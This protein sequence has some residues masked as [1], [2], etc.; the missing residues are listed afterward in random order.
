MGAC[1]REFKGGPGSPTVRV[2]PSTGGRAVDHRTLY[3]TVSPVKGPSS[4]PD[5]AHYLDIQALIRGLQQA[6]PDAPVQRVETHISWVL[7]TRDTAYKIK[8]PVKFTFVDFTTVDRR[9]HFCT[10]ELRLNRRLAPEIYL[11]VV[12][13]SRHR[14]SGQWSIDRPPGPDDEIVDWAVKMKA[15]SA[16]TL[17]HLD[18]IAPR[19]IDAI[20]DRIAQFHMRESS[21]PPD[22]VYGSAEQI[23]RMVM[24]N[25]DE[26]SALLPGDPTIAALRDWTQTA[27][28]RLGTW[29]TTRPA[30]GWIKACHGDLHLANITLHHDTPVIFDCIEFSD[31]LRCIDVINEVAFLFMDLMA[32][33]QSPMAW[34]FVN[35][36]CETTGD[37]EGLI[38]LPL[39]SIYRALVRAK[40]H[41][42]Q[43]NP[44]SAQ[45][46]LALAR[47]LSTPTS[48]V[49]MLM[50]GF[51]GSGKTVVAQ[52]RL[53]SIGMVRLRSDVERK[54]LHA[55]I[56]H[57]TASSPPLPDL[58]SAEIT[59]RTFERLKK[60]ARQ[61][62]QAG[63][64]VIVDATFLRES[65]RA[66]FIALA[67]EL[68]VPITILSVQTDIDTCRSRILARQSEG[69]DAS[70][71][72]LAV[73]EHQWRTHDPLT[74]AERQITETYFCAPS[75]SALRR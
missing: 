17:N 24:G 50:H 15:F 61:L 56:G 47:H 54:R 57:T 63:L 64:S 73:L 26:L 46:Y 31:A 9:H 11:D 66:S 67:R 36:W 74:D 29:W 25:L 55:Q 41:L 43:G 23:T 27:L 30:E 7:I 49:L 44:E 14:H 18:P 62:M 72:T 45:R 21:L 68:N 52:Q 3:W 10:E 16:P 13:I 59:R 51:S 40:I 38:G 32:H 8:K 33:G 5:T 19:H 60:R 34:R 12:P 75:A 4:V 69:Q 65:L 1:F 6:T 35:R 70:D 48:P 53:E 58:Y 39:Y 42:H 22:T 20:A 37:Y 28:Q 2:G 71:A